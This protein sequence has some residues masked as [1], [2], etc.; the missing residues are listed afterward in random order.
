MCMPG[1]FWSKVDKR[2]ECGCWVWTGCLVKGYGM[3][4]VTD[5]GPTYA[6]RFSWE[7]LVGVIPDG[8]Q[9]DHI[10]H[11][12]SCVNPGHMR[13]ATQAENAKN[14]VRAFGNTSG[15]KGVGRHGGTGKWRARIGVGGKQQYLGLFDSAEDAYDAYCVA[16]IRLH[17][18]FANLGDTPRWNRPDTAPSEVP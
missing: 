13:L 15:F 16:A 14:R 17:G 11:R 10:C 3:F 18:E 6:H 2:P 4:H 12:P 1:R 9:L 7:M 8:M 5:K